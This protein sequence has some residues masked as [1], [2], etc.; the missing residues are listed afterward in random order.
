MTTDVEETKFIVKKVGFVAAFLQTHFLSLQV[1]AMAAGVQMLE[2]E[3][4][5]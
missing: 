2:L 5:S 3:G 4:W 1:V